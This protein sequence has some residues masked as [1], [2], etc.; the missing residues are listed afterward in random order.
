MLTIYD[1]EGVNSLF[2]VIDSALHWSNIVFFQS[3]FVFA[4]ECTH[5]E[6]YS[7]VEN[8][9]K[10]FAQCSNILQS[11]SRVEENRQRIIY[12]QT[13]IRAI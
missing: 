5:I 9:N 11:S 10:A 4:D 3:E 7:I 2:S 8:Q 12:T 6:I 13:G 1:F